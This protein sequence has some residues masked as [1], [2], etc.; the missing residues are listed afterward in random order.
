[1][2]PSLFPFQADIVRW[3]V[4]LGRAAIFADTGLGKT[5]MQIEWARLVTSERVLI[6]SPL[7][8]AHQTIAEGARLGVVITYC[9]DMDQV[10]AGERISI[11]NYEM[12]AHFE[13]SFFDAVVLDESSILKSYSGKTKRALVDLFS[14]TKYRLACTAT[15]APND[16]MELGNHGEF[17]GIMASNEML[18]R[19][20]IN[21]T[22]EAGNYR[23]K[24]H[25]AIDFWRWITSWA[26]A[27]R[28]PSDVRA[29][30]DDSLYDLPS[31]SWRHHFVDVPGRAAA[32]G[33]LYLDGPLSATDIWRDKRATAEARC[34]KA[35]EI[36]ASKPDRPWVV[37]CDTNDESSRLA[38]LIPEAVE[39]RGD[40]SLDQKEAGLRAFSEGR[41]RV[42]VTKADLAGFG[43]NWQHC[44]DVV[45]VGL[46][47]SYEKIYQAARRTWRFGQ[48]RQVTAHIVSVESEGTVANAI[49]RKA[50][51]HE[52]MMEEMIAMTREYGMGILGGERGLSDVEQEEAGGEG[53]R[54]LLGDCVARARGLETD[55]VDFSVYSPPFSNLYIYSDSIA[56]MG[57][58]ADHDEFFQHYKYLIGEML[59]VTRPGRLT[60]VHCKDLPLYMNRDG[61]AGLYDF[62]GAIVRAHTELGWTFHS[63]VTIWKDPATEMQR[64][65]NHGLLHKHFT[66]RGEVC[67]QGMADFVLIFRAWKGEEMPDNQ[68]QRKVEPGDYC[69]ENPPVAWKDQ[70]DYSIQTWQRY[71][72]PV[73]FDVK[74]QDVLSFR[75]AREEKDERHICP[76]QLGVIERCVWLWSNPGDLVLSPFAGIGSEG[77]QSL[78]MGRR[79][80]GIE[81]KRSYWEQACANLRRAE[82][83]AKQVDLFSEVAP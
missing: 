13:P 83:E 19:W 66:T 5:R 32:L 74:Q 52:R 26:V 65:K 37:W 73:W 69:G 1:V 79:F 44:S 11:A 55:S 75:E 56:D 67:R 78:Q 38:A 3:S 61:A 60:A 64:T 2:H 47:Y 25:A 28:R 27:C 18:A 48:T 29:G 6:L 20:F 14:S 9:R 24:G 51:D 10:K 71:A 72:S 54:M 82:H 77:Y 30:Y 36:V 59:R 7:A 23:L 12:L 81:L 45:F 80:L 63:R 16:H 41:A 42:V 15:P 8:V 49:E 76:L 39:V 40:Q 34:V 57:N 53:W 50:A 62:P 33:Y 21:D 46:T 70:V 31:L 35:A 43:L 4:H 58:S 22:M 17:L 68:I